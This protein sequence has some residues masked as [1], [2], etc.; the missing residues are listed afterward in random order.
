MHVVCPHRYA[1]TRDVSP[2]ATFVSVPYEKLIAAALAANPAAVAD[3]WSAARAKAGTLPVADL[4]PLRPEEVLLVGK[5]H[6]A[7]QRVELGRAPSEGAF[8]FVTLFRGV[9]YGR[10]GRLPWRDVQKAVEEALAL[11]H[12]HHVEFARCGRG[13]AVLG[14]RRAQWDENACSV[15]AALGVAFVDE[16]HRHEWGKP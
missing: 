3:K 10:T 16:R 2:S 15:G 1:V 8:D 11:P 14:S 6:F 4:P 12:A 5:V 13:E 7:V 9:D